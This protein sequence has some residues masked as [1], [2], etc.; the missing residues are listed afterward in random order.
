MTASRTVAAPVSRGVG[1]L[2]RRPFVTSAF[3]V[4]DDTRLTGPA[5]P[6]SPCFR[7]DLQQAGRQQEM[8]RARALVHEHHHRDPGLRVEQQQAAAEGCAAAVSELRASQIGIAA[9]A[10]ADTRLARDIA[11]RRQQSRALAA[12]PVR[13]GGIPAVTRIRPTASGI[14]R[15]D[16]QALVWRLMRTRVLKRSLAGGIALWFTVLF[17]AEGTVHHCAMHDMPMPSSPMHHSGASG[18][19]GH[20]DS[21][22]QPSHNHPCT[23]PQV[24]CC[25]F[26]TTAAPRVVAPLF[27]LAPVA[28]VQSVTSVT[29]N[30]RTPL[31]FQVPWSTGPPPTVVAR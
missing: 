12:P 8:I 29:S 30:R 20:G 9:N 14:W 6:P 25:G 19:D 27:G 4:G 28:L 16:G 5:R 23:C 21:P 18:G 1:S 15:S 3:V 17:S 31:A 22:G 7:R 2:S 10:Q 11:G 13:S 24:C 26:A